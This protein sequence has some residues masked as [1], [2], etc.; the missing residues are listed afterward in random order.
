VGHITPHMFISP[1]T[2]VPS[3]SPTQQRRTPRKINWRLR[4]LVLL[5]DG[6]RCQLCGAEARNGATLQVDHVVSWSKGGETTFANLQALCHVCSTVEKLNFQKSASCIEL[7]STFITSG[8]VKCPPKKY[9]L[10]PLSY[11]FNNRV[12]AVHLQIS[13]KQCCG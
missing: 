10:L 2:A 5:R 13:V 7:Q 6:A 3:S 4:S 1:E 12:S 8:L 9:F 11:F